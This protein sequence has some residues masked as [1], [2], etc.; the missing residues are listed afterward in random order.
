MRKA[1]RIIAEIEIAPRILRIRHMLLPT[2][3]S[4][5]ARLGDIRLLD[6]TLSNLPPWKSQNYLIILITNISIDYNR[7]VN[8]IQQIG[9]AFEENGEA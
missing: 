8:L 9:A 3:T 6:S 5:R 2:L 1:G 4:F 7:F